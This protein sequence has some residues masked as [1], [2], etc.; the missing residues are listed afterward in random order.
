MNPFPYDLLII[1][2]HT[3]SYQTLEM[4]KEYQFVAQNLF[5]QQ[6]KRQERDDD[7]QE[8]KLVNGHDESYKVTPSVGKPPIPK[9]RQKLLIKNQ[10]SSPPIGYVETDIEDDGRYH[11]VVNVNPPTPSTEFPVVEIT[12]RQLLGPNQQKG[13]VVYPCGVCIGMC[14]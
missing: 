2:D 9:P 11:P 10:L 3:L 13:S 1:L 5:Q 8:D 4:I 14:V 7:V 6:Q 12:S